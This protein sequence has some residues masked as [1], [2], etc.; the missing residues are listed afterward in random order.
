M[1]YE[2]QNAESVQRFHYKDSYR[3]KRIVRDQKVKINKQ[4][5]NKRVVENDDKYV[6][7]IELNIENFEHFFDFCFQFENKRFSMNRKRTNRSKMNEKN[8]KRF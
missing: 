8:K 4:R 6:N 7:E 5:L 1:F 2:I 3:N